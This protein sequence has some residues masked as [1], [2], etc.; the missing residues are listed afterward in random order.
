MVKSKKR[1]ELRNYLSKQGIGTGIHYPAPIHL[2]SSFA[3]LGY[4]KGDFPESE[5]VSEQVL[6][7]PMYPELKD[8]EIEKVSEE[9]IDFYS[10]KK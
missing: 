6:S 2:V 1:D 8:E 5:M 9:I 7:L 3:Y 10:R 4:R